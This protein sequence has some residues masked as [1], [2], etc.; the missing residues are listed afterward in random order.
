MFAM[1]FEPRGEF[2]VFVSL[3]RDRR[4]ID[5]ENLGAHAGVLE[6][7]VK[8][9]AEHTVIAHPIGRSI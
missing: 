8:I 3:R 9:R 6:S 5:T 2:A 7:A 1:C 4:R